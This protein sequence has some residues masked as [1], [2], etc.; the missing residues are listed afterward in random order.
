MDT[1]N[2]IREFLTSRRARLTPEQVGLR[3]Y[4]RRRV[5]GLRRDEVAQL[6]EISV[7]Y[8]SRL[9]RGSLKGV[10]ES[11][12]VSLSHALRLDDTEERHL[13]DLMR[14][15][16]T[17]IRPARPRAKP[18]GVRPSVQRM[19]D[20]MT[21]IPAVVQNS[22]LDMLATNQ[23]GRA[24]YLDHWDNPTGKAN[25]AQFI[26]LDPRGRDFAPDWNAAATDVVALLRAAAGRDPLDKDLSDL[27][28][29]LSTRSDEFRARWGAHN[30]L[31]QKAGAKLIR[32]RIVGE[33]TVDF[34]VLELV[35]APGM[36]LYTYSATPGSPSEDGLR[37][38]STWAASNTT[39]LPTTPRHITGNRN[40]HAP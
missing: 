35:A 4:G 7:E 16:D 36:M 39:L 22:R 5:P 10:S 14:T 25:H 23:L 30:V 1:H 6:A 9:E 38:L 13:R 20:A 32:H 18:T 31:Q 19:L 28:G 37:L 21:T 24:F 2:D 17:H 40:V 15:A 11:V 34:D 12:L 26:F 8:Y 3:S 29:E 27:I 33:L